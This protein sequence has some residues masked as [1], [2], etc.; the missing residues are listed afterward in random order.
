MRAWTQAYPITFFGLGLQLDPD[1]T[2]LARSTLCAELL[3]TAC[4]I[5]SLPV[6]ACSAT[7][8]GCKLSSRFAVSGSVIMCATD[9]PAFLTMLDLN[10]WQCC[11]VV[12]SNQKGTTSKHLIPCPYDDPAEPSSK[13]LCTHWSKRLDSTLVVMPITLTAR[14]QKCAFCSRSR[15]APTDSETHSQVWDRDPTA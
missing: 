14:Y 3:D 9:R 15:E 6:P 13:K 7:P 2:H 5:R 10:R 12:T 4:S 1:V 8:S 11:H